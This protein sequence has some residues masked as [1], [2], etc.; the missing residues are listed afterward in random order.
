MQ[1]GEGGRA[2]RGFA[3]A[4]VVREVACDVRAGEEGERGEDVQAAG[5]GQC[6]R[7]EVAVGKEQREECGVSVAERRERFIVV[8]RHGGPPLSALWAGGGH[9]A[10]ARVHEPTRPRR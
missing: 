2:L 8:V 4:V 5:V 1:T 6:G 7:M 3:Q 9:P 10:A